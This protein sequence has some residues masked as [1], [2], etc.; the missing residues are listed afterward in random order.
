MPVSKDPAARARQVANLRRGV[1]KPKPQAALKHGARAKQ[2]VGDLPAARKAIQEMLEAVPPLC[3]ADG[4]PDK[5]YALAV[6]LVA[7][8]MARYDYI[9]DY[10]DRVGP[11]TIHGKLR[12]SPLR[13]LKML[14][15]SIMAHLRELGLTP[16]GRAA[17]GLDIAQT[18]AL[19]H[20]T[21]KHDPE[22][23]MKVARVMAVTG[24]LPNPSPPDADVVESSAEEEPPEPEPP[25]PIR[26]V[27]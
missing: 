3:E 25:T 13:Q 22:H 6:R 7:S 16:L 26:R 9:A 10:V 18:R 27:K 12:Y 1:T 4:T 21:P 14:E 5:A 23:L 20:I 17:L 11:M 2:P 15:K 24:M 8:E 19:Q